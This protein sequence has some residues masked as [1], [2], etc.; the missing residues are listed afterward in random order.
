M[1]VHADPTE[2]TPA[3]ITCM[4]VA[5]LEEASDS[6]K[7]HHKLHEPATFFRYLVMNSGTKVEWVSERKPSRNKDRDKMQSYTKP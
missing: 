3:L 4:P 2:R 7:N 6:G 5:K 1:L